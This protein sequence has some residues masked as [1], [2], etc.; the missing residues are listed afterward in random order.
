MTRITDE[1]MR[2]FLNQP[3][4]TVTPKS[5]TKQL[6]D[7]NAKNTKRGTGCAW[8]IPVFLSYSKTTKMIW[9]IWM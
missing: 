5:E 4:P 2:I 1:P 6:N 8:C 3:K 7:A 9:Y